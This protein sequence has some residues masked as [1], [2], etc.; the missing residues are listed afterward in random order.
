MLLLVMMVMMTDG[1]N[2]VGK[3]DMDTAMTRKKKMIVMDASIVVGE[4]VAEGA[5]RI[6]RKET[7]MTIAAVVTSDDASEA[8]A[9]LSMC[10]DWISKMALKSA[11]RAWRRARTCA[12]LQVATWTARERMASM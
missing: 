4:I 8:S 1:G 12:S 10:A 5:G 3:G 9:M 2:T 7:A 6:R 11:W